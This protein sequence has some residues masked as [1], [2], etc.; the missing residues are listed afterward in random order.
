[1]AAHTQPSQ[2]EGPYRLGAD[3][4][5]RRGLAPETQ[6]PLSLAPTAFCRHTPKVGAV[7]G[8]AA[9]TVLCGGRSAMSVPTATEACPPFKNG[10]SDRW[11]ARCALP[12]LRTHCVAR[13]LGYS[14]CIAT[15]S[16]V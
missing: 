8:K 2:P 6:N 10:L 14:S 15:K 5:D 4:V 7:C 13:C 11:W 9:R 16:V 3:E 12:T 1:M